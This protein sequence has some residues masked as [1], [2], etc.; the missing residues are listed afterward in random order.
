MAFFLLIYVVIVLIWLGWMSVL[1]F[2]V[3]K[4]RYPGDSSLLILG[5]FIGASALILLVSI[6]FLSRADWTVVPK[7]LGGM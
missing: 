1:V 3:L 4:Y 2:H 5:G 6:I 7:I